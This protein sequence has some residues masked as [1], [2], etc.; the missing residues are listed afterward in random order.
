MEPTADTDS[1]KQTRSPGAQESSP[2]PARDRPRRG[3]GLRGRLVLLTTI[4]VAVGLIIGGV[5]LTEVLRI[6]LERAAD[7]AIERTAQE[8]AQLI[9]SERLPDPVLAGGTTLVQVLDAQGRVLAASA[10]A[11]RLV[12]ALGPDQLRAV[13]DAPETLSGGAF[14]LPGVVRVVASD[15]GDEGSPSTVLV[16]TPA[17]DIDDAVRVVRLSLVVGFAVLLAVSAA[18][19]WRLVGAT[20]RPVEALRLGAQ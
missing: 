1:V 18:V 9:D 11:D 8:V 4:G 20:L 5:V 15:A 17:S 7:E 12:A 10:G 13:R 16:A 19:V 2:P 3:L 14:G 6:G